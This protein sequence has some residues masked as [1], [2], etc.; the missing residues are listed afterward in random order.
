MDGWVN[1]FQK[2]KREFILRERE[3]MK[4]DG[5]M[6]STNGPK[7]YT[8]PGVCCCTGGYELKFNST[9]LKISFSN[10][11]LAKTFCWELCDSST[12]FTMNSQWCVHW[13]VLVG[14]R[15]S[16]QTHSHTH[17]HSCTKADTEYWFCSA[18]WVEPPI[19]QWRGWRFKSQPRSG[20]GA[21]EVA[22]IWHN[23]LVLA[24]WKAH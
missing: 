3:T 6:L 5:V 24:R 19:Y 2:M 14:L 20:R 8:N 23:S 17:E 13:S 9:K 16:S 18:L 1:G 7:L 22:A 21:G 12:L 10:R 4:D 11:L 15:C